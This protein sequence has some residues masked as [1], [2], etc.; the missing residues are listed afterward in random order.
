MV[1]SVGNYSLRLHLLAYFRR[2]AVGPLLHNNAEECCPQRHDAWLL[3][4]RALESSP[5]AVG[6]AVQYVESD[7]EQ[8]HTNHGRG[9][10]FVLAMT[11]VVVLVLGLGTNLHEQQHYDVCHEVGQGVHGIGYHRSRAA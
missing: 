8:C 6:S 4:R 7:T 11:I 5:R 3:Y 9:K 1:P 2:E 10:R